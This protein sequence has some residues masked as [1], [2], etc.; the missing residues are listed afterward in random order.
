MV[1]RHA[2][3]SASLILHGRRSTKGEALAAFFS[4][5]FRRRI[6]VSLRCVAHASRG[7]KLNRIAS[8]HLKRKARI[9][10]K[11]H[12]PIY[13]PAPLG[14]HA[15][16]YRGVFVVEKNVIFMLSMPIRS[17]AADGVAVECMPDI[18]ID[19]SPCA[20]MLFVLCRPR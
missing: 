3:S 18:D 20:T 2:L 14:I 6:S 7:R 12:V 8:K 4:S 1:S 13:C 17:W 10:R 16:E 19:I 9:I 5:G 15:D 11:K